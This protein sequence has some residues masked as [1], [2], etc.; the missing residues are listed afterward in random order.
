MSQ[1]I[2]RVTAGNAHG[3]EI[4][5]DDALTIG[6]SMT[7]DGA[8]GGDEEISREHARLTHAADGS[9]VIEDLGSTNGTFVNGQRLNGPR[10]LQ[11]G[12]EI[13]VG[14]THLVLASP[15]PAGAGALAAD[16]Q[17]TAMH[18]TPG[19][20]V[21]QAGLAT[22][23]PAPPQAGGPPP[24]PPQ[25]GTAPPAPPQV[26]TAPPAPPQVGTPGAPFAGGP[27]SIAAS[28]PP[29]AKSGRGPL[30]F[31]LAVL[32]AAI[33]IGAGY[34][35]WNEDTSAG[36]S[37]KVETF[38]LMA[39]GYSTEALD[40]K[41]GQ[42]EINIVMRTFE[43]DH[44]IKELKVHKYLDETRPPPQRTYDAIYTFTA[45]N[46]DTLV[47][48][49]AGDVTEPEGPDKFFGQTHE[50]WQ[51]VDGTGI[52]KGARGEGTITTAVHVAGRVDSKGVPT[53]SNVVK[54]I[55][56]EL[57]LPNR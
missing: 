15:A 3:T 43:G 50:Q 8:L 53:G 52:F 1:Q 42:R 9:L 28:A 40:E 22:P 16:G 46:E 41:T 14:R 36:G 2:L 26:G 19:A 25:V 12:D 55:E 44:G 32:A 45:T 5:F 6:R 38:S 10:A 34:L 18:A 39:E 49:A 7:G 48:R 29:P 23:P 30:P 4:T 37:S 47:F 24:A 57:Q 11:P 21:T 51:V 35:I 33:G 13:E 20:G 56:G 54:H 27:P 31:V 17:A